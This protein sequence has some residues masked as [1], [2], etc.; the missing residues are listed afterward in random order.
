MWD[1]D[2]EDLDSRD[3]SK[4]EMCLN[5]EYLKDYTVYDG[6]DAGDYINL[7]D[8]NS[9]TECAELCCQDS[10]CFVALMLTSPLSGHKKCFK[11]NCYSEETCKPKS[12]KHSRYKPHLFKRG[13]DAE[14][15]V[16][17]M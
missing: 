4:Y 7:G 5:G 13:S 1:T 15:P 6:E 17:G 8:T 11:I 3:R 10:T 14:K 2:N 9:F 16:K 12:A